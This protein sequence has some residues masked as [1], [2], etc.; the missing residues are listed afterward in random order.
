VKAFS[1]V[2]RNKGVC[3][4]TLWISIKWRKGKNC[5]WNPKSL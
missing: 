2:R 5:C 1:K 4:R 3:N